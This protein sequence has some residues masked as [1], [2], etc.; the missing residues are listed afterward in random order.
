MARSTSKSN[1]SPGILAPEE[2]G[3]FWRL[4]YIWGCVRGQRYGPCLLGGQRLGWVTEG[5]VLRLG[6]L[7]QRGPFKL[8]LS[9]LLS[10]L[11][12]LPLESFVTCPCVLPP[13]LPPASPPPQPCISLWDPSSLK[14]QSK[15]ISWL[16]R[17]SLDPDLEYFPGSRCG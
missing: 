16:F 8:S 1:S 17:W 10:L 13:S 14:V 12:C 4:F 7:V 11:D 3:L 5:R 6:F 9:F 2:L 15:P